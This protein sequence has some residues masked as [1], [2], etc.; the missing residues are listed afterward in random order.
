MKLRR[1]SSMLFALVVLMVS[2]QAMALPKSEFRLSVY[3]MVCNQCAY[4]V[5]QSLQHTEGVKDAIVDLREGHVVVVADPTNPPSAEA[6]AGRIRDQ[7]VSLRAMEA[8]LSGRIARSDQG[9]ELLAG[10][11]RFRVEPGDDADLARYAGESV[12]VEGVFKGVPGLEGAEGPS[13]LIV[14]SVSPA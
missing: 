6:L 2:A 7:R 1:S 3:G 5:E 10:A 11:R 4:G 8:T 13:R 9:W 12:T 14:R